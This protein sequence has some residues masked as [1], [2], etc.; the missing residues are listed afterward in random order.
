MCSKYG[1]CWDPNS[2]RHDEAFSSA[3]AHDGTAD[4]NSDSRT[5]EVTGDY[6]SF[7]FQPFQHMTFFAWFLLWK[8]GS[9]KH[10]FS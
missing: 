10:N 9:S 2:H 7:S 8:A 1:N 6:T 5:R 4:T 3:T